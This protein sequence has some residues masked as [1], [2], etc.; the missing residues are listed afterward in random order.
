MA[1]EALFNIL[2][3]RFDFENIKVLDLFS[4]TGSISLEFASRGISDILSVDKDYGCIKYLK[5]TAKALQ[6]SSI[7]V[8]RADVLK[9]VKQHTGQY[10]LIFAD[11]PYD[12]PQLREIPKMIFQK[13]FLTPQGL[14]II[15][16]PTQIRLDNYG[17]FTEQ[18]KY[19][20]S[21]FSFF[22]Q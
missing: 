3:N 20:N 9:F 2:A 11:P 5:E 4:G 7:Q 13:E 8:Q 14:L 16:H 19:G 1:K 18:R 10:D 15:E 22:Q 21:T 17:Q 12:L 6:F